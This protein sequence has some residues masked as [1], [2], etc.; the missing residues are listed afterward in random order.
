MRT[1]VTLLKFFIVGSLVLANLQCEEKQTRGTQIDISQDMFVRPPE[2]VIKETNEIRK[3]IGIRT[4]KDEWIGD[5]GDDNNK[6]YWKNDKS[7][8]L[9]VVIYDA[10]FKGILSESDY[11]YTGKLLTNLDPDNVIEEHLTITYDY[12]KKLFT[13]GVFSEDPFMVEKKFKIWNKNERGYYGESNE[14]TLKV[15]D[16]ILKEWGMDR[17]E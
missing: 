4:I 10:D 13:F 1:I 17:F 5:R 7:L 3:T 9:K 16:E 11:Y 14:H 2:K 8:I 12:R 6:D 15:A